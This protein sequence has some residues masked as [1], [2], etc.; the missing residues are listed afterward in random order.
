MRIFL[1]T[2]LTLLAVN[3]FAYTIKSIK[4]EGMVHMSESVALR[5]LKFEVGDEVDDETLDVSIKTYYKQ[6][7]FE[8]IW[9]DMDKEGNLTF[10]FKEKPLISKIELKG[11]KENDSDTIKSIIQIKVGSLYDEKKLEAAKKRIIEA[12]NQDA[13]ID[14]VVEIF[15]E[16]LENGSM[17]VTFY[18]NEGEEIIIKKLEYSGLQGLEGDIFDDV[19]ANKEHEFMGWLWGRN[20]GKMRVE[21]SA[22]DP[23]RIRDMYMQYGYLDANVKEPF[24]KVNFDKYTADISYQIKEGEVYSVSAITINQVQHVIEDDKIKEL[25]KL[26]VDKP[27]NI[28]TFR[29]DSNRI[30]TLI[31]DLSY[32]FV[33]IVPDLKKN[34]KDKTVEVV[35]KIMPGE[36]VKIRD[37][38]ISGNSRTL[39]RIIRRELYLG[40]GDMYSLTDLTDS[41]S[42][43]GRLGFFD[44]NT[45]EEKRVDN[46]TMDL[47][48]KVKEAP[49]GNIQLGGGYGSYGGLLISVAVNDRNIWGS[50]IDMGIKAERSELTSTYSFNI[51]NPR[52]NDSDFSG[53]FSIYTS[54]YEYNDYRVL[55]DGLNF[56]IG[57][58]FTRYISGYIGYEFSKNAYEFDE[59][60]TYYND[61]TFENYSKSSVVLSLKF[62]NTDDFYLPRSGITIGQSVENAGLGA[63]ASFIKTKT[64]FGA[65]KGLEEYF[66]VDIIARY[67]ARFYY[68]KETGFLPVAERFYM[69]GIGSVR[70]YESYSISPKTK[71]DVNAKDGVRRFG[72]EYTASNNFELS[73]PL[74]PKAKMRLVTYLDWG[75]IATPEKAEGDFLIK[76]LSRGGYGAGLEWFSPVGPIQ[77]MFSKPLGQEAGDKT[78]AFEFTMGQRF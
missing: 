62:D 68:V 12:I 30:K 63:D 21:D 20:D 77:L 2:L 26:E 9:V 27:F 59:N 10:H 76:N 24:V 72:G 7:Y 55:S 31:A 4:Y 53:N 13:K 67:K 33:Q 35:F 43:L 23:L 11:W 57:H 42:A 48:V 28:K 6:N 32:A 22:Y 5:M 64:T 19:I 58:R 65:Y 45:I 54:D 46:K 75:Y 49:T 56:G 17:K 36:R 73:F 50:G 69:G 25:I 1:A 18:V 60:S 47:I 51:S 74:V 40:P 15:K 3:S 16:R 52:L 38:L 78:A 66:G 37:V 14:S 71:L 41:R 29:E 8:D 70:G 34:E 61:P 39:D 44:G